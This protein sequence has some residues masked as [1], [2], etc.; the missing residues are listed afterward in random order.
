MEGVSV[1]EEQAKR[2]SERVSG[3]P[4]VTYD[5][6]ALLYNKL[7]GIAA[8]EEYKQDAQGDKEVLTL[9][10]QLERREREDVQKLRGLLGQ[11]LAS[12]G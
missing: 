12:P 8:L 2:Q 3:M 11:R 5:L 10:Q 9:L 4:N 1:S 6:V 7:Q